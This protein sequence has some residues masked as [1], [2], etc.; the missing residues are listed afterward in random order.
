MRW[1]SNINQIP[2]TL[3][4]IRY[5]ATCFERM[6]SFTLKSTHEGVT[7]FSLLRKK[8]GWEVKKTRCAQHSTGPQAGLLTQVSLMWKT[9]S[10]AAV[11]SYKHHG[12]DCSITLVTVNSERL[13]MLGDSWKPSGLVRG[14]STV[15]VWWA[16][17]SCW[18]ASFKFR[19]RPRMGVCSPLPS[20]LYP[21]YGWSGHRSGLIQL[22]W[23][24]PSKSPM[25]ILSPH[26]RDISSWTLEGK[27]EF[28]IW[29]ISLFVCRYFLLSGIWSHQEPH[30]K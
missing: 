22:P 21:A 20:T 1:L 19:Q 23:P 13:K 11:P 8:W 7:A 9:M 30:N 4:S 10:L 3:L 29:L 24:L 27:D 28:Q 14:L 25:F 12:G 2:A 17:L 6:S 18:F 5:F 15:A 16:A 26:S